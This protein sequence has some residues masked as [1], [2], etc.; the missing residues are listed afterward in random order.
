[1]KLNIKAFAVAEAI[2]GAVLFALCRLAFVIAPAATLA[3]LRYFT[4]IDWSPVT[5]PVTFGGFVAGLVVFTIFIAAV[6]AAWAWLYNRFAQGAL[7]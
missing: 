5:M 3:G 6:G 7:A 1:M 4:H 2:V